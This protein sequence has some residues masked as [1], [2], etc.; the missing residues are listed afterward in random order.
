MAGY[1]KIY[2]TVFN[3]VTQA[4]EELEKQNLGAAKECLLS[5]QLMAGGSICKAPGRRRCETAA[6]P[7]RFAHRANRARRLY[8]WALF[9]QNARQCLASARSLSCSAVMA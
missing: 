2:T 5:A 4:L 7:F 6:S 3:A 9:F 8:R 1:Q